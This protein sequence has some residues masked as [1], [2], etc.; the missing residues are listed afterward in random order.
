MEREEKTVEVV[1]VAD[2]GVV[3]GRVVDKRVVDG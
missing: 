1:M 3:D 2:G